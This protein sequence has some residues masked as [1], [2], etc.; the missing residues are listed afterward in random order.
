MAT[1][2]V[3]KA[4]VPSHNNSSSPAR[5]VCHLCNLPLSTPRHRMLMLL[6]WRLPR[7]RR[8]I[9]QIHRQ[10]YRS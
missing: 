7:P 1:P 6:L 3:V 5:F 4:R 8:I 10:R 2:V 9:R